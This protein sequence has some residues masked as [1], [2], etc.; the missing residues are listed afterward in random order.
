MVLWFL[1]VPAVFLTA[2]V[3]LGSRA[4]RADQLIDDLIAGDEVQW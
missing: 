3:L 4:A 1:L 2:G